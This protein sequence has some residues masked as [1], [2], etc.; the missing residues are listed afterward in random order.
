MGKSIS[1]GIEAETADLQIFIFLPHQLG[2]RI[3]FR[4]YDIDSEP[5]K[6]EFP[7]YEIM[8]SIADRRNG[9]R[10]DRNKEHVW[11]RGESGKAAW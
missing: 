11:K 2:F 7:N 6:Y 1:R 8:R 4:G 3:E 10:S 9:L 5:S